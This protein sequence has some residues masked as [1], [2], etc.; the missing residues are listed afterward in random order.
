[1]LLAGGKRLVQ[2]VQGVGV[3]V[4]QGNAFTGLGRPGAPGER[5]FMQKLFGC[6]ML[7]REAPAPAIEP[8]QSCAR[9]AGRH[10]C[11]KVEPFQLRTMMMVVTAAYKSP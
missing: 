7:E 8:G 10:F 9:R 5:R 6:G 1:M 4:G 3:G 2:G 11:K